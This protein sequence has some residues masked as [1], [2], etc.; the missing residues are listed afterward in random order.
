MIRIKGPIRDVPGILPAKSLSTQT[1]NVN[2]S[3]RKLLF[4]FKPFAHEDHWKTL[5][6]RSTQT[7]NLLFWTLNLRRCQASGFSFIAFGV[8]GKQWNANIWGLWKV[9]RSFSPLR[10]LLAFERQKLQMKGPR[11]G[12]PENCV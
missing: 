8:K 9:F 11:R 12:N 7:F 10:R 6:F 3:R 1:L 4:R 2:R 5:V